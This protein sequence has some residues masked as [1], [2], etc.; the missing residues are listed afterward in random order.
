MP[1]ES[2]RFERP[3]HPDPRERV[4]VE[5]AH[6]NAWLRY[7]IGVPM[8]ILFTVAMLAWS[9][10][11]PINTNGL[12]LLITGVS[13][14][15]ALVMTFAVWPTQ[16]IKWL[17]VKRTARK[18][19]KEGRGH[20]ADELVAAEKHRLAQAGWFFPVVLVVASVYGWFALIVWIGQSAWG[21]TVF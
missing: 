19:R 3:H 4:D 18:L 13:I 1:Y 21:W 8:G 2:P 15:V 20:E 17:I 10:N 12:L 11:E 5:G 7:V 6:T 9:G 16:A 14:I